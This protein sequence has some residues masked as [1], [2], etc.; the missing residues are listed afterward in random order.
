[1]RATLPD[2]REISKTLALET[3]LFIDGQY[4][5]A[6]DGKTF[7][8]INPATGKVL[9]NVAEASVGDVDLAVKA[10]RAAFV[11]QTIS[12]ENREDAAWVPSLD[13]ISKS[14]AQHNNVL[15]ESDPLP[16]PLEITGLLSAKLDFTVNVGGSRG[17]RIAV[18]DG[19]FFG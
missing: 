3:R 9:A 2:Y 15:Y 14:L 17:T 6:E 7:P 12:L 11:R 10:A 18:V 1:M 5:D 4:R 16:K 8:T 19:R 13:L